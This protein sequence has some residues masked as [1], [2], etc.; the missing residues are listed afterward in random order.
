MIKHLALDMD[1]T[2]YKGNTLFPF[3]KDFLKKLTSKGIEY[4][5]LTNNPSRSTD[6][7]LKHLK[8]MGL[9][10]TKNEIYTTAQATIEY[11]VNHHPHVK[12]LFILGTPSMIGEF[13]KAGFILSA[14]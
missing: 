13:E 2:I 10:V 1:G 5:F 8:E 4:S 12:R 3:T 14:G 11:L 9:T 7:Y 6:D